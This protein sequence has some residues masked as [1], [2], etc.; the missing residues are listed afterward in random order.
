M[1]V[2]DAAE[3]LVRAATALS[4]G[5]AEAVN[6]GYAGDFTITD[7]VAQIAKACG[8]DWPPPAA[9]ARPFSM[10]LTR[11][12]A[13]YGAPSVTFSQRLIEFVDAVQRDLALE[14]SLRR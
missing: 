10:R 14:P 5:A 11:L 13:R 8:R 12:A 9:A 3:Y 2:G 4:A 1:T 7:A 6:V